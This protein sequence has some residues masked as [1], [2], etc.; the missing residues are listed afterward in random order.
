MFVVEAGLAL[1][2]VILVFIDL[3]EIY[4]RYL[5]LDDDG[6][7]ALANALKESAPSLEILDMVDITAKVVVFV[8]SSKSSKQFFSKLNLSDNKL[9]DEGAV[10]IIKALEEGHGQLNEVDLSTNLIT[11]SGA[12]VVAGVVVQKHGFKLLSINANFISEE[13]IDELKNI[14][15]KSPDL[16]G[17]LDENDPE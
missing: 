14:F 12:K 3:T 2:K 16:L 9:K 1:S 5:N 7:E 8:A 10:L 15:K 11:W 6:A 17:P 4:L 13:G